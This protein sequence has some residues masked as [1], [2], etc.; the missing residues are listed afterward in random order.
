MIIGA[1]RAEEAKVFDKDA[2]FHQFI[3]EE[4]E[5]YGS[6][7][8]FWCD[9]E[10]SHHDED[11]S[12]IWDEAKPGWYWWACFPGCLPDSDPHGPFSYSWEAKEDALSD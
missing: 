5:K 7:E 2:G 10:G 12:Y 6:F 1:L 3:N 8:V 11:T 4:G 9:G